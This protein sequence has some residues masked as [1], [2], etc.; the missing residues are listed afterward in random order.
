MS[1]YIHIITTELGVTQCIAFN[2]Y[3]GP[4]TN[5][6]LIAFLKKQNKVTSVLE[7]HKGLACLFQKRCLSCL[8]MFPLEGPPMEECQLGRLGIR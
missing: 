1:S 6:L 4:A 8:Q 5:Y 7:L 3:V 2:P